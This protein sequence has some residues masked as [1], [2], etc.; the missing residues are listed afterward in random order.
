MK[1]ASSRRVKNLQPPASPCLSLVLLSTRRLSE[2][3]ISS[4][5]SQRNPISAIGPCVGAKVEGMKPSRLTGFLRSVSHARGI[6]SVKDSSHTPPSLIARLLDS[7]PPNPDKVVING[8]VR[9]IRNQKMR[10]FASIGDGSSLEPMQ[11]L[12]TPAQAQRSVVHFP[13]SRDIG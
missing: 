7:A 13:N 5:A 2:I 11:A 12:L 4:I 3:D 10:S 9:S 1:T 6:H 8:F